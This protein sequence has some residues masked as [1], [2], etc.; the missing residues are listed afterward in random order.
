MTVLGRP[1]EIEAEV[2]RG[3]QRGRM[4]GFP[5]ANLKARTDQLLPGDGVYAGFAER[6][7]GRYPAAISVGDKPTFGRHMRTCE[8][9]LL[10]YHG[11]VDDY[12]WTIRLHVTHWLR[13]QLNYDSVEALIAQMH[14]DTDRARRL[15]A[16]GTDTPVHANPTTRSGNAVT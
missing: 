7:G 14:R 3:D 5:T 1:F 8:A 11:P 15:A 9:F 4:I 16:P 2:Q 6:D 10:D 12:G 13:D